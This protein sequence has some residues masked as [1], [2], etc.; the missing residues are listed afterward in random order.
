MEIIHHIHY[1]TIA[2]DSIDRCCVCLH[3][4]VQIEPE[5]LVRISQALRPNFK[6]LRAASAAAGDKSHTLCPS[7]D[8]YALGIDMDTGFPFQ[9][10]KGEIKTIHDPDYRS[11]WA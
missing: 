10:Q 1:E 8:A 9:T 4:L 7:C 3:E 6:T 5:I 2:P 11:L